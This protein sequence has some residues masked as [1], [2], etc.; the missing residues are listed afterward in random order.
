M[1]KPHKIQ[2]KIN[3]EIERDGYSNANDC[4]CSLNSNKMFVIRKT[5][6]MLY[7]NCTIYK[8]DTVHSDHISRSEKKIKSQTTATETSC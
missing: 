8:V 4:N 5:P 7:E 6:E 1:R 2:I 3:K